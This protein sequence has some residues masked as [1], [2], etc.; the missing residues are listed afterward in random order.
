MKK[1]LDFIGCVVDKSGSMAGLIKDTVEG[2]N[3]FIDDQ[4]AEVTREAKTLLTL[5]DSNIHI[6][7]IEDIKTCKLMKASSVAAKYGYYNGYKIDNSKNEFIE[8]CADGGT[9][10]FDALG[11]TINKIGNYLDSLPEDEK[12]ENVI[13]YII[14]DGDENSSHEFSGSKVKEMIT[15]QQDVYNWAFIFA[16]ANID[17][18]DVAGDLGIAKNLTMNYTANALGVANAYFSSSKTV[19]HLRGFNNNSTNFDIN[20]I[21]NQVVANQSVVGSGDVV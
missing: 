6:G 14:T 2:Y 20:D 18:F 21:A 7:E 13:I 19:S 10:Y 1:G 4:K 12:P 5:F 11:T 17:A 8:Y 16:G 15:H 3:K 9:A